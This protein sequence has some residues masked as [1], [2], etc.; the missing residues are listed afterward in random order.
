[1]KEKEW[2]KWL[3]WFSFAVAAI[4]VYKT[5]DSLAVL[6]TWLSG[7]FSL[8]MPFFMA[9]IV[10]YMLYIPSK[11]IEAVYE[12]NKV[13]KKV[14]RGLSVFTTYIIVFL[15]IFIITNFVIP[16]I[17]TSI[18]EL[19]GSL[20]NY[21]NSA[22]EFFKEVPEDS[23]WAKLNIPSLIIGLQEFDIVD[24]LLKWINLE[25]IEQYI[26]GIVG[27]AGIIFDA[28]VTI[29]VSVYLL[30]ERDDIKSF[31][32]NLSKAM[33]NKKTCSK[34]KVYFD[35][36]NQ[37]FYSFVSSQIIDA[38][39]VGIICGI[40]MAIMKVK[41]GTLLALLIGVFNVIPYFGAIFAVIIAIII[42]IFTGGFMKALWVALVIIILQQIDANIIN[43]RILGSSLNLS[44][45]LV[46]FAVTV[47]GAYFG[48]LGMFLGVPFMAFAKTIFME[49]IN[50]K[51][52]NAEK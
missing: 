15:V 17:S 40:A 13:L 34:L 4:A 33:F 22:I 21:Y 2:K 50:N 1:M 9:G 43:P 6:L 10:A 38:I 23:I 32:V 30:L 45:I 46:I 20:P 29:V 5:I 24:E 39:I 8:M 36:T 52:K 31:F 12:K 3:F 26:K 27:A 51:I 44:P 19:A 28:F 14:S 47:G 18:T 49:N 35:K 41:Y 37:I 11:K 42:T 7:F 25:N 16:A 48:I